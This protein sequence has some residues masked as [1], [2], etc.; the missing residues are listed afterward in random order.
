MNPVTI[1]LIL[2]LFF[3][4]IAIIILIARNSALTEKNKLYHEFAKR[5]SVTKFLSILDK[6]SN[7]AL[8]S[9][10]ILMLQKYFELVLLRLDKNQVA[11]FLA[12]LDKSKHSDILIKSLINATT[13]KDDYVFGLALAVSFDNS[14]NK[15]FIKNFIESLPEEQKK[16]Q[17]KTALNVLEGEYHRRICEYP[18]EYR[19]PV[20]EAMKEFKEKT[21]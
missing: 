2:A 7:K 17:Y 1:L 18:Y 11:S 19:T 20:E 15:L 3:A 4:V 8:D 12:D 16:K 6:V 21:L 14:K 10:I 5:T 13:Q 9:D